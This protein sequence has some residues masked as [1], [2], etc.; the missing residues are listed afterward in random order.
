M[1][2]YI[3][4][5][6]HLKKQDKEKPAIP[7]RPIDG[8]EEYRKPLPV[9]NISFIFCK[10]DEL[11]SATNIQIIAEELNVNSKVV[12]E[13]LERVLR[14]TISNVFCCVEYPY[15]EEYYRDSY[16]H[17]IL[18]SIETIIV[19]VSECLFLSQ[20]LQKIIFWM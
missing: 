4:K 15:I 9:I 3:K 7:V 2:S 16:F 14:D 12:K 18:V 11:F 10:K 6:C 19:I 13:D 1:I 20:K 5:I 8:H 17:S